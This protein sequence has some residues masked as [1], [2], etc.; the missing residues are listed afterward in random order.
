MSVTPINSDAESF[1]L[2]SKRLQEVVTETLDPERTLR[3]VIELGQGL[4]DVEN[5]HVTWIEPAADYWEA[6]EST[7]QHSGPVVPG[8]TFDLAETYCRRVLDEEE[9][10]VLSHAAEQGWE[11]DPAYQTHELECYL[12]ISIHAGDKVYGTVCFV[13]PD[14]REEYFTTEERIFA[15]QVAFV[16]GQLIERHRLEMETIR[17]EELSAVLSRI[18]RH[19]LRNELNIIHAR[20]TLLAARLEDESTDGELETLLEHV[21]ELQR[22]AEKSRAVDTALKPGLDRHPVQLDE[23]L[24]SAMNR[25]QNAYPDVE[26]QTTFSEVTLPVG[27]S[28]ERAFDELIEN[29]AKHGGDPPIVEIETRATEQAAVVDIADNG[30]GLPE[31]DRRVFETSVETPLEHGSGLGLWL[32]SWIV[33]NH[34]GEVDMVEFADGTRLRVRL[35]F[36]S[37]PLIEL[38]N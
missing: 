11:H 3:E 10:I 28:M 16:L 1:A 8:E 33:D 37:L 23:L 31:Y 35:P 12:G 32:V 21:E 4:L 38:R 9:T 18:L 25:I 26:F 27:G 24:G 13:S 14:P 15:E 6:I 34:N 5:A 2:A 29:A 17:R 20:A 36:T 22:L 19:N 30:P 7:D